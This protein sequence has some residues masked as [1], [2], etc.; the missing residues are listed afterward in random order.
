[1]SA[2][3]AISLRSLT[4]QSTDSAA[5]A[6]YAAA[7]AEAFRAMEAMETGH[8]FFRAE[9]PVAYSQNRCEP[10]LFGYDG[11][12]HYGSTISQTS[13]D[14]LDSVGFDRCDDIWAQYGPGVTAAA[15]ALLGVR[16][17]VTDT[18][19]KPYRAVGEAGGYILAANDNALPIGWTADTSFRTPVG[20]ENSFD[21]LNALYAAAAPELG[22]EIFTAAAISEPETENFRREGDSFTRID[23][24]PGTISWTVTARADGPLYAELEI[25][26]YPGVMLFADGVMRTWY[27][28][29]QSNGT[30]YLG[31]CA[32]GDSVTVK[33]QAAAD[34]TVASAAFAT[35]ND[36]ALARYAA[37][38]KTGGCPLTKISSSHYIGSFTAPEKD[39]LLVLT[40]PY[41][42][43][44]HITLDGKPVTAGE[45]QGCLTALA[46]TPGNHTVE[47]RYIPAGL[48]PGAA[49]SV[50]TLAA[51][52]T[53]DRRNRKKR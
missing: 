52:I 43:S 45:V 10:M 7:K 47:L 9:S 18:L 48:I 16:Y 38:L 32:R 28:T 40:L 50:L 25:P 14:F 36:A 17:L 8:E 49:I 30:V 41:D 23:A 11:L 51:L 15:D 19:D 29:T 21:R 31:D 35:E 2:N 33:L 44:W 6:Q 53:I 4:A 24:G 37:A 22:E 46:V 39:G 20:G 34:V 1:M 5:Y 42:P 12:S 13:L 26:D 3:A 27:A